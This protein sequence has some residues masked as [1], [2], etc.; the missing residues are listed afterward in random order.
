[1]NV[2]I[3]EIQTK[4]ADYEKTYFA[5]LQ[6]LNELAEKIVRD[7]RIENNKIS[8]LIA[9]LIKDSGKLYWLNN[10]DNRIDINRA[11]E[12]AETKFNIEVNRI[13]FRNIVDY[14]LCQYESIFDE[15]IEIINSLAASSNEIKKLK[16]VIEANEEQLVFCQVEQ[17]AIDKGV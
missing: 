12:I 8:G 6:R 1:M 11:S 5:N 10:I 15:T 14:H 17:I 13:I 3:T 7:G 4:I 2:K 9:K 16:S